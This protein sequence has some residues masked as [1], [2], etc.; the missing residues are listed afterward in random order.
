MNPPDGVP[1]LKHVHPLAGFER[2]FGSLGGSLISRW[3]WKSPRWRASWFVTHI[4]RAPLK[5]GVAVCLGLSDSARGRPYLAGVRMWP[6]HFVVRDLEAGPLPSA[7]RREVEM[8]SRLQRL[9]TQRQGFRRIFDVV[10]SVPDWRSTWP[11]WQSK[12]PSCMKL[13]HQTDA[14]LGHPWS[15]VVIRR[16]LMRCFIR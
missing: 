10:A 5:E 1:R 13:T 16:E 14:G 12:N 3:S 6:F 15:F 2:L 7:E 9:G 4:R 11:S 8:G